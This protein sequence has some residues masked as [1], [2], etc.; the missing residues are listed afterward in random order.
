MASAFV[1]LLQKPREGET[2]VLPDLKMKVDAS[3]FFFVKKGVIS[4]VDFLGFSWV[5]F[6]SSHPS[7]T[8]M[9]PG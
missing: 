4:L 6:S 3:M 1:G 2:N 7:S 9:M 5:S 8:Q